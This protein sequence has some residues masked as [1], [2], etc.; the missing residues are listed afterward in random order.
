[1]MRTIRVTMQ[2]ILNQTT[3]P[4]KPKKKKKGKR[5]K[6]FKIKNIFFKKYLLFQKLKR[7]ENY[8]FNHLTIILIL[9]FRR[10]PKLIKGSLTHE[11][12]NNLN[13]R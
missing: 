9:T 3:T 12:F 4:P 11:I 6:K 2:D 1:M 5:K 13:G 7:L 8:E 10:G